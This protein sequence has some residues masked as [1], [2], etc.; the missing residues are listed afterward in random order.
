ME[1][2]GGGWRWVE[3][4][5]GGWRWVEVGGGGW[6][7]VEVGGGGWGR[8]EVREGKVGSGKWGVG[9]SCSAHQKPIILERNDTTAVP[10]ETV[11]YLMLFSR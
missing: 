2:G 11:K 4:G 7:W 5:G 1:V 8:V 3:V 10:P 9:M 6:R